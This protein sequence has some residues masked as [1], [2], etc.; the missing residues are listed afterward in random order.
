M[1]GIKKDRETSV[2]IS[3]STAIICET[4]RWWASA[5]KG[6]SITCIKAT[7]LFFHGTGTVHEKFSR[8]ISYSYFICSGLRLPPILTLFNLNSTQETWATARIGEKGEFDNSSFTTNDYTTAPTFRDGPPECFFVPYSAW[9]DKGRFTLC[10]LYYLVII[11][12]ILE[13]GEESL[14]RAFQLPSVFESAEIARLE[15]TLRP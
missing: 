13:G 8:R 10:Y 6:Y 4:L 14:G 1:W 9:S 7:P 2:N 12:G 15:L 3:L 11:S 5:G